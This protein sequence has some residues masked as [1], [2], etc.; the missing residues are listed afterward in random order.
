MTALTIKTKSVTLKDGTR[1]VINAE[2][3]DPALHFDESKRP[4]AAKKQKREAGVMRS[5]GRG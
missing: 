1:V 5:G 2:D 3:F 4:P